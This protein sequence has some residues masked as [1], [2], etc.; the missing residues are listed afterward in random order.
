VGAGLGHGE[1][2]EDIN[3]ILGLTQG[4]VESGFQGCVLAGNRLGLRYEFGAL[5]MVPA[6]WVLRS[7]PGYP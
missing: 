5:V 1:G 6:L 7:P 3:G 4:S 2:S